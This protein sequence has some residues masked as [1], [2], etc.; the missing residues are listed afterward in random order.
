MVAFHDK[1][2]EAFEIHHSIAMCQK[3]GEIE[4]CEVILLRHPW[5]E[6]FAPCYTEKTKL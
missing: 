2:K 3:K 5:S 1:K 4:E 6:N